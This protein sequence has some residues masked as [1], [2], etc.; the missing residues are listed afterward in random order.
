ML[1]EYCL[2]RNLQPK[3]YSYNV[4]LLHLCLCMSKQLF[5]ECQIVLLEVGTQHRISQCLLSWSLH[6]E[7]WSWSW[8]RTLLLNWQARNRAESEKCCTQGSEKFLQWEWPWYVEGTEGRS[9]W[10]GWGARCSSRRWGRMS[11]LESL[12][13]ELGFY[14]ECNMKL[15]RDFSLDSYR[16]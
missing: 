3:E 9:M 15:S 8:W 4:I 2:L 14:W 16:V 5:K 11:D 1:K 10:L 12:D 13:T 6:C 7:H